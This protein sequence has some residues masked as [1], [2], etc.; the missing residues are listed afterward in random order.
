MRQITSKLKPRSGFAHVFHLLLTLL[1]PILIFILVR[2]DFAQLGLA[3][4]FLSKWRMF[5]VRPRHWPA[6][7][8]ANA[9][10]IMVGISL[11]IFMSHSE[12]ASWQLVWAA[13]YTIWLFFI[14]PGS[15]VLMVSTQA[16]IAQFCGLIALFLT[17]GGSPLYV[18]VLT[19]WLIC[20]FTARHFFTSFDEPLA[21]LFAYF[22]GYFAAAL[23]WLLGHWLL[24]YGVLAQP[25]LLLTVLGFGLSGLYYLEESDRL[26]VLLRRQFI[27]IMI[28]IV[29]VVLVFSDWG[30]KAL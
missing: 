15:K 20:Y 7:V 3:L 10:D 12:T 21:R 6:N 4:I 2:I 19:S 16:M 25:A 13:A 28:A 11:L 26:S 29:M 23:V 24:F 14:K 30:D 8:R 17:W 1:L 9:V 27:F 5:A 22:W 18:L